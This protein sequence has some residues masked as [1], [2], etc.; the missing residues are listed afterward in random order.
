MPQFMPSF[1]FS[2]NAL[3]VRHFIYEYWCE[4]GVAPNLRRACEK[5]GLTREQYIWALRELEV[6][7]FVVVEHTGVSVNILKVPPFSSFPT[8]VELHLDGR[9]HSFIG[10]ALEA[11][12][13]S[14]MPP[15]A[16]KEVGLES[17][18]PCCMEAIHLTGRDGAIVASTPAPLLVHLSMTPW[19]WNSE[20]NIAMCDSMNFVLDADHAARHERKISRRGVLMDLDQ[21]QRMVEPV[22]AT[23]MWDY[24]RQPHGGSTPEATIANLR[25]LGVDTS[26]W[27]A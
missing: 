23:R 12:A 19:E 25:K 9:F 5:T 4:T 3:R 2:E 26:N 18:C 8:Q 22:A 7:N 13:V 24:N 14:K 17:Y 20:N 27:E 1:Q 16:G 10:C 21:A 6:S 15:F 11:V